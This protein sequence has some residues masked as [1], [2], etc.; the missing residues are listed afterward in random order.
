MMRKV[1]ISVA[2]LALMLSLT[3][4]ARASVPGTLTEQGRLLDPSGTPV[5]GTVAM[6]FTIYDASAGGTTLWTETQ[7]ITL[8]SGYFSA[9]LG[10][11][12]AIPATA[13]N[14]S[15]RYLGVKVGSDPEMTPRQTVDSVPYAILAGN[16]NG[17]ITPNSVSINGTTV[18]NPMGQWVGPN[19]GL[20]GPAGPAGPAGA[21][22]ATGPA[23][24]AGPAG[25][26]GPAGP[27]GAA[28]ATGAMGPVGPQGPIGPTGA[29]GAT[30]AMGATG[31]TGPAG[32]AGSGVI[33]STSSGANTYFTA[34]NTCVNYAG[35]TVTVNAPAAGTVLVVANAQMILYHTT[36]TLDEDQI[37]IGATAMDCGD[38]QD[39]V[40]WSTPAA[41]PTTSFQLTTFTVQRAFAVPAAGTY[42]YYLN[43][44]KLSGGVA[45]GAQDNFNF[46]ALH[47]MYFHP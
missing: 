41:F 27:A 11:S 16:V 26:Q 2:V 7:S 45:A 35:G 36:G 13:F 6:V 30:G 24:P 32:P 22:G 14:G 28:G 17:D 43:G 25:A 4:R 5:A 42:T 9:L 3:A 47:A 38:W 20:V 12:V 40:T 8:D 31:A 44:W 23:G 46:A 15:T 1:L 29:T 10:Q 19:S 34:L 37:A 33:V 39:D 21:T 18:I